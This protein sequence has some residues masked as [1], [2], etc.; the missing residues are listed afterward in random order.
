M[1][2]AT[3]TGA[4][5]EFWKVDNTI[6]AGVMVKDLAVG[7]TPSSPNS[8]VMLGNT[9]YFVANVTNPTLFRS[10]GTTAGT[11]STGKFLNNPGP[12]VNIGGTL[13]FGFTNQLESFDGT[14]FSV[15][16][17]WTARVEST[18]SLPF[19]PSLLHRYRFREDLWYLDA[20]KARTTT[21]TNRYTASAGITELVEAGGA[22]FVDATGQFGTDRGILARVDPGSLE[23]EGMNF[24]NAPPRSIINVGGTVY[25]FSDREIYKNSGAKN[26]PSTLVPPVFPNSLTGL[27]S[28]LTNVNGTVY[29]SQLIA[30]SFGE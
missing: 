30:A 12:L 10:D 19:K 25:Y 17:E 14:T 2:T 18:V 4:G 9:L 27:L 20:N 6:Q 22:L 1:F 13:Y 8:F 28:E 16:T 15:L 23:Y 26:A 21:D 5:R 7:V 29:F 11:V 3:S 24:H